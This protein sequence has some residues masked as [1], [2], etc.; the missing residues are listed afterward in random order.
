MSGT[1][2][3]LNLG[4]LQRI[5]KQTVSEEKA[6]NVLK[7]EISRVLGPVVIT[8][9]SLIEAV[10]NANDRI[11][12]LTRTGRGDNLDFMA[13]VI[14]PFMQHASPEIRKF[15][16]RVVPQQY[17]GK[18]TDDKHG[19]VRAAVAM[20]VPTQVVREMMKKFKHDDQ[21]RT[22]YR[23][24][25]LH[26]A[27]ISAPEVVPMGTDPTEDAERMGAAAKTNDDAELSD[28]YYEQLACKFLADYNHNIEH[29]W[30]NLAVRRYVSSIKAT[31]GVTIDG[32]K[33]LKKIKDLI[34]DKE[35]LAMERNALKEGRTMKKS[36]V[37]GSLREAPEFPHDEGDPRDRERQRHSTD[38]YGPPGNAPKPGDKV[39]HWRSRAG[40]F[41]QP[42]QGVVASVSSKN[43][44][45]W[46][47]VGSKTSTTSAP[48]PGVHSM[49][50]GAHKRA[51]SAQ[52]F[53]RDYRVV[54][55]GRTIKK[56]DVLADTLTWLAKQAILDE[57]TAS[58]L[59][60][61]SL[62]W[63]CDTCGHV[64]PC[65]E[66]DA[67]VGNEEPCTHCSGGMAHV[68]EIDNDLDEG[69]FLPDVD[70]AD[71]PVHKLIESGLTGELYVDKALAL[72]K[73]QQAQLPRGIRKYLL[74]EGNTKV[75][76]VPCVGWLPSGGNFRAVDERA[77]DKLC[78]AWN[79]QQALAGEPIRV[80]WSTHPSQIGKI[81]FNVQ[82]S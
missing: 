72:F 10:S 56:N 13:E 57:G 33:L 48:G 16:A 4:D 79:V 17:L 43:G 47:S 39:E 67:V 41:P 19:A 30:E 50:T 18:M 28:A 75:T 14:T 36:N 55:E 51:V 27:G 9:G 74:G 6:A 61:G 80:S 24:R 82:L 71:D 69:T 12:V 52:E 25:K 65:G 78:E 38:L 22:I 60:P 54:K 64:E 5:V 45:V 62:V 76:L 8:D 58:E 68:E 29:A 21:L 81:G 40:K 23:Q 53:E 2:P 73:V 42:E 66:F 59:E 3:R 63:A 11:D 1:R 46:V 31:S 32:D 34:K 26:E 37:H 15:A 7:T 70:L 44:T 20:R 49:T 35:K 77:L